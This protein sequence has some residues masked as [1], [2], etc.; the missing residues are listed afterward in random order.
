MFLFGERGGG[1]RKREGEYV[2][3]FVIAEIEETRKT[4][5]LHFFFLSLFSYDFLTRPFLMKKLESL[6]SFWWSLSLSLEAGACAERGRK[7]RWR[8]KRGKEKVFFTLL[9]SASSTSFSPPSRF[10]VFFNYFVP[11][12]FFFFRAL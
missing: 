6:S 12:V 2:L 4:K 5:R 7:K 9:P 8:V 3:M 11:D 1:K 10:F